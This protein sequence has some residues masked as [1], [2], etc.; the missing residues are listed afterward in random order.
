MD[1]K[2]T[3]VLESEEELNAYSQLVDYL[4]EGSEGRLGFTGEDLT[5]MRFQMRNYEGLARDYSLNWHTFRHH[6]RQIARFYQYF[7]I[8]QSR[9]SE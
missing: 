8:T 2:M 5:K 1:V 3:A 9:N 4:I 6:Q 7:E